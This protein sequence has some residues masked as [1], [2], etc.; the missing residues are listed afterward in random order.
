M[1]QHEDGDEGSDSLEHEDGDG[2]TV[3]TEIK[4]GVQ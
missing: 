3:T 4:M 2:V 1:T